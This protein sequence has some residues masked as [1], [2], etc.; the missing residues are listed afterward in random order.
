MRSVTGPGL[1][2]A[3]LPRPALRITPPD[4]RYAPHCPFPGRCQGVK[5]VRF[6]ARRIQVPTLG[7]GL[8]EREERGV[9]LQDLRCVVGGDGAAAPAVAAG[10]SGGQA[11]G[12]VDGAG[13]GGRGGAGGAPARPCW[14][15]RPRAA[16]DH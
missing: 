3:L 4:V 16:R 11:E 12:G 2:P 9:E 13:A 14:W 1:L 15:G 5:S 7:G 6:Y 8:Q 10:G